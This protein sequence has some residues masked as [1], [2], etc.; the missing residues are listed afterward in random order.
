MKPGGDEMRIKPIQMT[1]IMVLMMGLV[2]QSLAVP[3]CE[4]NKRLYVT[5]NNLYYEDEL[6]ELQDYLYYLQEIEVDG[7]IIQDLGL[8]QCLQLMLG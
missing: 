8:S 6:A 7:L 3:A 2:F 5:V 4:Q 1:M